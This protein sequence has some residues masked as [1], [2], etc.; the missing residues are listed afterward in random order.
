MTQKHLRPNR[1]KYNFISD[2]RVACLDTTQCVRVDF[3]ACLAAR[4]GATCSPIG[5]P[6]RNRPPPH[7]RQPAWLGKSSL[8]PSRDRKD[9]RAVAKTSKYPFSVWAEY[10]RESSL[11]SFEDTNLLARTHVP[12]ISRIINYSLAVRAEHEPSL[13]WE[14]EVNWFTRVGIALRSDNLRLCS[15]VARRSISSPS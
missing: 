6:I 8:V 11:P 12:K 15:A 2:G 4:I 13:L 14:G 9:C 10:Y 3:V 7:G 1:A 5:A